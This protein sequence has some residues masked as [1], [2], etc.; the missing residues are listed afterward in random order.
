MRVHLILE[1]SDNLNFSLLYLG[2]FTSALKFI[3]LAEFY[4]LSNGYAMDVT[5]KIRYINYKKLNLGG[6]MND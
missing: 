2:R 1:R 5:R 3:N 4:L 6:I